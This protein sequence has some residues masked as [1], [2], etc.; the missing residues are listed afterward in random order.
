MTA[1]CIIVMGTSLEVEPF[2]NIIRG[3]HFNAPRLLMNKESVGPFKK[4]KKTDRRKDIQILGDLIDIVN[5]FV[6]K[7]GWTPEFDEL[8]AKESD[9]IESNKHSHMEKLYYRLVREQNLMKPERQSKTSFENREVSTRKTT[10]NPVAKNNIVKTFLKINEAKNSSNPRKKKNSNLN[11]EEVEKLKKEKDKEQIRLFYQDIDIM[12]LTDSTSDDEGSQ[13]NETKQ[14]A[15]VKKSDFMQRNYEFQL[16]LAYNFNQI[17]AL[18]SK[19]LNLNLNSSQKPKTSQENDNENKSPSQG[20]FHKS[21][22]AT[23]NSRPL[24][25]KRIQSCDVNRP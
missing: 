15:P 8:I 2:A 16:K 5:G 17:Q 6:N 21:R 22:L 14:L 12:T 7:L 10:T 9:L 19:F 11:I 4:I 20:F 3:S 23:A 24:L 1:D 25:V 18:E 13:K